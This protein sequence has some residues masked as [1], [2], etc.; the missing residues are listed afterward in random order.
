MMAGL[1]GVLTCHPDMT[2]MSNVCNLV[3]ALRL[4][5]MRIGLRGLRLI[6][7]VGVNFLLSLGLRQ[8]AGKTPIANMRASSLNSFTIFSSKGVP[9]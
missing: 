7:V 6:V 1:A 4:R 2:A 5:A 3:G 9:L 8:N